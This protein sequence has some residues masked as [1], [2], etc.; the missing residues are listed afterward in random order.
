MKS[1]YGRT[2]PGE[3]IELTHV[4]AGSPMGELLRRYWQPVAVADAL[5][6]LPQR[7]RI[8]GEDLVVFR[9][10]CG[11]VGCLD[12]HCAHRGSSLEFG[13]IEAD[14]LRCC[15]HGWLYDTEGRVI[16]MPC[17]AA[18]FC[19][20]MAVEHPAYPVL[21]F[22]GLV[23]IYMGPPDKQPDFPLYDVFKPPTQD[24]VLVGKKI[25]GDYSI[26]YVKDCN[27]LQHYENVVD[28]W[29]LLVL[30]Q[31]NSGDQFKGAMMQGAP[32]IAFEKTP[33]GMRYNILR[34]LPNGNRFLRHAECVLPNIFL[35]PNLHEPGTEGKRKDRCSEISWCVPLDNEHITAFSIIAWP[36]ENGEPKKN[37]RP[38]TDTVLDIRPPTID[39]PYE[40]RQRRPDDLEAQESQRPIAVHALETLGM[41]DMGI[42][43]L[44]KMLREQLD[45]MQRGED[46]IN[47]ARGAAAKAIIET[48]AWNTILS[49]EEAARHSGEDW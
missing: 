30:H 2:T 36:L 38:R 45:R 19:E 33:L 15:Y 44:R 48:H 42:V 49:P 31:S 34:D 20:R 11:K 39:R 4:E 32:H 35:V 47:V 17:E 25:W 16:D 12:L 21:E 24:V 7:V 5:K 1:A 41:S 14:G 9:S 23:F 22:G 46:P 18:G 13:R 29:H 8:L 28:P 6:D 37:W 10:G 26:G 43:A 27:W 3:T 40:E